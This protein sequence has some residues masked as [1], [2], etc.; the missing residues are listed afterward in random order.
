MNVLINQQPVELPASAS[1]ADAVATFGATGP[2][3]V[4]LNLR[5]VP[6]SQYDHTPVAEGDQI[7]I[8]TPVTGG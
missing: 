1:V 5:F 4:A 2:F 3:A 7:E 6:R 8:I